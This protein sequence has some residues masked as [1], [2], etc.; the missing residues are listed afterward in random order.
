[1]SDMQEQRKSAGG[2]G[3][4][5]APAAFSRLQAS[6]PMRSVTPPLNRS[7]IDASLAREREKGAGL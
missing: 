6:H 7:F 4:A 3:G 1:M 5:G 2:A